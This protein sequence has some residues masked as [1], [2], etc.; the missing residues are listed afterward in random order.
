MMLK[1]KKSAKVDNMP[2]A[3]NASDASIRLVE[4]LRPHEQCQQPKHQRLMVSVK[5]L[6]QPPTTVGNASG[7]QEVSLHLELHLTPLALPILG[8]DTLSES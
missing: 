1:K 7:V 4:I 3:Q 5:E 6:G 2:G 8:G